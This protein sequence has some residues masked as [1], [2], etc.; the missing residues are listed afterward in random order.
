VQRD[1]AL[2]EQRHE[3]A[4]YEKLLADR[5]EL[6]RNF[7]SVSAAHAT[8]M[9]MAFADRAAL[10]R[11]VKDTEARQRRIDAEI[12]RLTAERDGAVRSLAEAQQHEQRARRWIAHWIELERAMQIARVDLQEL[13]DWAHGRN[14]HS[15]AAADTSVAR[16]LPGSASHHAAGDAPWN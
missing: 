14:G 5:D 16:P 6:K 10:E 15:S 9:A 13:A 12:A 2:E 3:A 11:R 7:D 8:E 4:D 1:Q